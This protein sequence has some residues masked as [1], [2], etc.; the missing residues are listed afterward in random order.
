MR[1][2][3][4]AP[5]PSF[6]TD[7]LN[8]RI[9][10]LQALDANI[11]GHG[12]AFTFVSDLHNENRYYS[13]S[14][15]NSIALNTAAKRIVYG[16][17]YINEPSSYSLAHS[18]LTDRCYLFR[19]LNPKVILLEGNHDTNPYGTGQIPESTL[20]TILTNGLTSA[21]TTNG[22]NYYYED[23]TLQKIRFIYLNTHENGRVDDEQITWFSNTINLPSNWTVVIISHMAI[24]ESGFDVRTS[25]NVFNVVDQLEAIINNAAPEVACWICGHTHIDLVNTSRFSFPIIAVTCDAHGI[26]ASVMSSDARVEGTINEQSLNVFHINTLTK[27]VNMTRIGGGQYNVI[28]GNYALNDKQF[29]YQ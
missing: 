12:D 11:E 21:I 13:T 7:Y 4:I 15:A 8:N 17:D 10:T 27:T 5:V 6:Y 1:G 24:V 29:N 2:G 28:G 3:G 18:Q 19:S 20:Q 9:G 14:L 26:Q 25:S 16:G 22:K 23:N